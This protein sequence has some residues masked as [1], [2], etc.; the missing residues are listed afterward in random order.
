[1]KW[2]FFLLI[3]MLALIS[4]TN[5]IARQQPLP[6]VVTRLNLTECQLP[7]WSGIVPGTTRIEDISPQLTTRFNDSTGYTLDDGQASPMKSLLIRDNRTLYSITVD[8]YAVSTTTEIQYLWLYF[9][10]PQKGEHLRVGDIV[11]LLGAPDLVSLQRGPDAVMLLYAQQRVVIYVESR[12]CGFLCP[13]QP[14][15]LFQLPTH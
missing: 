2:L 12:D 10:A 13:D 6:Q 4:G 7:C 11:N 1:M 8:T 9:V 3:I 14:V 15:L 5:A